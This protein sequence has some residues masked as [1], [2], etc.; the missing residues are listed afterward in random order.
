VITPQTR[1]RSRDWG[2]T[3]PPEDTS[4][5]TYVHPISPYPQ[6]VPPP[7][8]S[9]SLQTKLLIKMDPAGALRPDSNHST[10]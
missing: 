1:I 4:S 2:P 5:M 6:K 9:I 3:A 7:P 10:A 8:N